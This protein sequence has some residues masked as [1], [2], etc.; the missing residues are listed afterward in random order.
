MIRR[1]ELVGKGTVKKSLRRGSKESSFNPFTI[2]YSHFV[3]VCVCVCV[4][5]HNNRSQTGNSWLFY[6]YKYRI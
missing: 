3:C 1:P 4:K 5:R 2:I 6:R